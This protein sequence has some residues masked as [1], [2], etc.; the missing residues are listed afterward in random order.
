MKKSKAEYWFKIGYDA[1]ISGADFDKA[2]NQEWEKKHAPKKAFI[3]G[4]TS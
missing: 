2:F 4:A 3:A 1:A